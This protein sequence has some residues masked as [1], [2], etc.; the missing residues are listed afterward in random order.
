MNN[1]TFSTK[2]E[3]TIL[4]ADDD[5]D[6]HFFVES[7]IREISKDAK[8]TFAKNGQILLELV[9]T[10]MPDLIFLDLN[11]PLL[12]GLDCLKEL[13]TRSLLQQVPIIIYST[14]AKDEHIDLAYTLGG[15]GYIQKPSSFAAIKT[16]LAQ[17]FS[18]KHSELIPQ[19]DR[20]N[21]YVSRYL[22]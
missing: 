3:L 12:S 13:R 14:G 16:Q 15:N 1:S 20:E 5:P 4:I 10:S 17:L 19:P 21:F 6:D 7:A 9:Q 2:K 8:I 11:M 22:P 18:L